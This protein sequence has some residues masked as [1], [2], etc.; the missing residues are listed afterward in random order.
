MEPAYAAKFDTKASQKYVRGF[1]A[2]RRRDSS[3]EFVPR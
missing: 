3:I 2:K 1:R